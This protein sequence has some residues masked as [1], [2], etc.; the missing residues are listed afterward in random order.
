MLFTMLN[1]RVPMQQFRTLKIHNKILMCKSKDYRLKVLLSSLQTPKPKKKFN[2]IPFV[3]TFH[4]DT[5]I[6][7][8]M[9][10]IKRK[11][12]NTSSDY[13]KGIVQESNILLSQRQPK[14]L[15]RLLSKSSIS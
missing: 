15:L 11:I 4:E 9:N 12:E 5:N 7:F 13:S 2:N 10:S 8:I 6:K 14:K 3:T 1:F